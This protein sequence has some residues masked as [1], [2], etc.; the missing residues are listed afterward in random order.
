MSHTSNHYAPLNLQS[1]LSLAVLQKSFGKAGK[2]LRLNMSANSNNKGVLAAIGGTTGGGS[3]SERRRV[4]ILHFPLLPSSNY[5]ELS[6]ATFVAV[7][8]VYLT[9]FGDFLPLFSFLPYT[10]LASLPTPYPPLSFLKLPCVAHNLRVVVESR[11][12]LANVHCQFLV[13]RLIRQ[14]Y[15]PR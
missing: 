9:R 12:H 6:P 14:V 4:C 3:T 8:V 13:I 2:H 15:R 7:S 5:L 1:H 10:K 11:R